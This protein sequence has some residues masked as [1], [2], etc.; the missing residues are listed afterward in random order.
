MESHHTSVVLHALWCHVIFRSRMLVV[1]VRCA[2]TTLNV[3]MQSASLLPVHNL[4]HFR[5]NKSHSYFTQFLA[6][7]GD[8]SQIATVALV[9]YKL[10]H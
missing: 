2:H 6:E 7:W 10:C 1:E 5:A 4:E 8:R 3:V 9:S